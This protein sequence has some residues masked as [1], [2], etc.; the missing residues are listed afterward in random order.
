[1]PAPQFK[2][3]IATIPYAAWTP[4]LAD[5]MSYAKGQREISASGYDHWQVVFYYRKKCTLSR[6]KSVLPSVTHLE[7]SRSQAAS[8]YVWKEDTRV[9]G[10]QFELGIQPVNRAK[11]EDW[12]QVWNLAVAGRILDIPSDIRIRCYGSLRRISADYGVANG[13]ERSCVVYY[14]PTG[15]G[16]SRRA[17]DEAGLGSYPKDPRTKFW[18]G[19]Q[20]QSNVIIGNCV[21]T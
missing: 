14:G 10:T 12:D 17:W 2:W 3:F 8:E 16:K 6:A 5:S 11:A 1:M 20:G 21:L 19:Y 18:C 4:T 13:I 9:A 15:T 7:P